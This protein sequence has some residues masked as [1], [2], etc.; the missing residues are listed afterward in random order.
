MSTQALYSAT[1]LSLTLWTKVHDFYDAMRT[2]PSLRKG[3]LFG[4]LA[5]F[6]I[7]FFVGAPKSSKIQ[8][9]YEALGVS[10]TATVKEIRSAYRK[11]SKIYMPDVGS[12]PSKEM[13]LIINKAQEILLDEKQRKNYDE[14]GD[15]NGQPFS[16]YEIETYPDQLVKGKAFVFLYTIIT[17]V[18]LSAPVALLL[19]PML[20]DMPSPIVNGIAADI[21]AAEAKLKEKGDPTSSLKSASDSLQSVCNQFTKYKKSIHR[22]VLGFRIAA[23]RAQYLIRNGNAED[24]IVELREYRD[25]FKKEN[26]TKNKIL[27]ASI[28]QYLDE[29]EVAINKAPS[30]VPKQKTSELSAIVSKIRK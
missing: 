4:C 15:P 20:E 1:V 13:T 23:R 9:P 30:N 8:D 28:S 19:N 14:F 27:Q 17:L 3:V 11:L 24:A 12:N 22:Y 29:L 26:L 16:L 10:K 2:N 25:L 7:L 5:I 21:E 6:V 18:V